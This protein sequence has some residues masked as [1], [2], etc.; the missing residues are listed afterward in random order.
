MKTFLFLGDSITDCGHCF[1]SKNLGNGYVRIIAQNYSDQKKTVKILNKGFNG[2][3]LPSVNRLWKQSCLSLRPDFFT[4]LVGI[5][6][7]SVFQ[8]NRVP[9]DEALKIF[10]ENYQLLLESIRLTTDCPI[11][12]MEPFIFPHPTEYALWEPKLLKLCERIQDIAASYK[13]GFLPLWKKLQTAALERGYENI[14][15]DGIHLTEDGHRI[16]AEAWL[17]YYQKL[18]L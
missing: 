18:S 4:I 16:V 17:E 6:D 5:N 13:V 9:E 14:T 8:I 11:L 2:F 7:L 10:Q 3:T 12:L 15:T 1:D